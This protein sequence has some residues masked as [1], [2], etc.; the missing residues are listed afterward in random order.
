MSDECCLNC[1]YWEEYH[2]AP[3]YID[4]MV[5]AKG[6]GHTAP[7]DWCEDCYELIYTNA[8]QMGGGITYFE[9]SSRLKHYQHW[10]EDR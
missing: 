8:I 9:R 6:R 5:C 10:L 3:G 4:G 7:D 1:R 2:P